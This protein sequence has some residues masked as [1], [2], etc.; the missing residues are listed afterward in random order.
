MA[1]LGCFQQVSL[2]SQPHVEESSREI[3]RPKGKWRLNVRLDVGI[4][5]KRLSLERK[6]WDCR[7]LNI[8]L[9]F[10]SLFDPSNFAFKKGFR[11]I[12]VFYVSCPLGLCNFASKKNTN[13]AP[14]GFLHY[15]I[16]RSFFSGVCRVQL[17]G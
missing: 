11:C 16:V 7:S 6:L 9:V 10:C 5:L 14:K 3:S 15:E 4:F 17:S 13:S 2:L 8:F 12:S 1:V